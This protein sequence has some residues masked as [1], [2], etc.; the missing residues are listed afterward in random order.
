VTLL[1]TAMYYARFHI[2]YTKP[3]TLARYKIL[4]DAIREC[5]MPF[6][7]DV[8][9][10]RW[11]GHS[12]AVDGVYAGS[13]RGA[14]ERA[15]FKLET[16]LARMKIARLLTVAEWEAHVAEVARTQR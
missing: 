13:D 16:K 10:T 14:V 9:G 6:D 7:L 15:S 3:Y 11:F 1:I 8:E 2:V 5:A 4:D 12:K